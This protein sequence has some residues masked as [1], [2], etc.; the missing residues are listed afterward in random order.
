MRKHLTLLLIVFTSYPFFSQSELEYNSKGIEFAKN[1]KYEEAINYFN[2]AINENPKFSKPYTNKGNIYRIQKN[3]EKAITFYSKSIEIDSLN[4]F[5]IE[6]RA[7]VLMKNDQFEDAIKDYNY[8]ISINPN[9]ENIFSNRAYAYIR[10]KEYSKAK[11]DLTR[12]LKDH[13]NDIGS[14][15]NL[16]NVN[17]NLELYDEA[18]N[19][20]EFLFDN[21]PSYTQ[22][23]KAYNNRGSLYLE[24]G[25]Y[26]KALV[27][28]NKAIK[29]HKNYDLAY[30][31]RGETYMRLNNKSKACQD[32]KKSTKLNVENNKYFEKDKDYDDLINFCQ[33]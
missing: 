27:D 28:Y 13:E 24:I 19:K 4:L 17:K 9:F 23:H 14:L 12:H 5:V 1:G 15:I 18:L 10:I 7:F 29:T 30:L 20:Y 31:G 8:I 6:S 21:F 26:H 2:K 3:Y 32:L 22:L 25:E 33:E 16:I 11:I